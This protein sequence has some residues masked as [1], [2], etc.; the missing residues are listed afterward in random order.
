V[1][2]GVIVSCAVGASVCIVIIIIS[3]FLVISYRR[4]AQLDQQRQRILT[5]R[6][7]RVWSVMITVGYLKHISLK[8]MSDK[9]NNNFQ[10]SPNKCMQERIFRRSFLPI[11]LLKLKY[12]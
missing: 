10:K 5:D 3:I 6:M 1:D 12:V 7:Q 11:F 8:S 2:I 9:R 4:Q